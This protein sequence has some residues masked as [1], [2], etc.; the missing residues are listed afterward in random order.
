MPGS[1]RWR[2]LQMAPGASPL[3]ELSARLATLLGR[4]GTALLHEMENDV[5]AVDVMSRQLLADASDDARLL[6]VVDQF[7][8]VFTRCRDDDERRRFIETLHY[9]ATIPGGRT[10][11]VLAMRADFYGAV[12]AYPEFA[13]ALRL[14]HDLISPMDESELRT[15]IETPAE[16]FGLRLEAGLTDLMLRDALG[17]PGTLP[18]LSHALLETWQRRDGQTLTVGGYRDAG[19]IRGAIAQTAEV[20]FAQLSPS[21]Q[22]IARSMFVRLTELGE[23]TEDTRR[24]VSLAE[25]IP[26]GLDGEPA[27]E[28]LRTL[29]DARLL[30]TDE[31]DVEVAHEALMREWPRLRDWLNEDRDGL[32]LHRHLTE[33][34]QASQVA[35]M[36]PANRLAAIFSS[37][38]AA[39]KPMP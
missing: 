30:T 20:T 17:E 24:R 7:E 16:I 11:V 31:S 9:A 26:D 10:V 23:G 39:A 14:N 32:R 15:A 33:S 3:A 27:V 12:T 22:S 38:G 25:L 28:V 37:V 2:I 4:E 35:A 8:E 34:A 18:L 5:R 21:E 13:A 1:A 29:T 6:V 36:S 19:G